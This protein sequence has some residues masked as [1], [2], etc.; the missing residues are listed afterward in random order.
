[1]IVVTGLKV[2]KL[3]RGKSRRESGCYEIDYN[4]LK[5]NLGEYVLL[6]MNVY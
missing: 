4:L 6:N 5:C 3:C 2:S 1:M